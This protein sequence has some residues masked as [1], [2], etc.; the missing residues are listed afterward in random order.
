MNY[1]EIVVQMESWNIDILIL[2][3]FINKSEQM[4]SLGLLCTATEPW[5]KGSLAIANWQNLPKPI[6]N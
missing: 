1:K 2:L 4:M 6:A 3:H 5:T